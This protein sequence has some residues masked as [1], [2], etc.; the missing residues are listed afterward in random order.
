M[1]LSSTSKSSE[2]VPS[3]MIVWMGLGRPWGM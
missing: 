2:V 3:G 1:A